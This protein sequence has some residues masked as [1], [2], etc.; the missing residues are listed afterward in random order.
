MEK[1]EDGG[2]IVRVNVP[3]IEG[4]ANERVAE[5]LAEFLGLPK[6]AIKLLSGQK[7]KRKIFEC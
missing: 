7:S 1:T 4:R 5:L 6:S 2:F 3:P